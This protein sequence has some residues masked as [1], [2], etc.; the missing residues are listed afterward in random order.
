M[1]LSKFV[2]LF[3]RV[4]NTIRRFHGTSASNIKNIVKDG[5][6]MNKPG[7]SKNKWLYALP[8]YPGVYT[9]VNP[10][11]PYFSPVADD[12]ALVILDIPKDAYRQLPRQTYNAELPVPPPKLMAWDRITLDPAWA[13]REQRFLNEAPNE[14]DNLRE[15]I[16]ELSEEGLSVP[17][18]LIDDYRSGKYLTD[19]LDILDAYRTIVP[20]QQG[21]RVDIFKSDLSPKYISDI[22]YK[23]G[24]G[25]DWF[26]LSGKP[27]PDDMSS[28]DIFK[29]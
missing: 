18:R 5:L 22:L 12:Q 7:V 8:E 11:R 14:Y 26:T 24:T 16:N 2:K 20:I 13:R 15:Q 27:V 23:P 28:T 21:G 1:P 10:T 25:D 4:P 6:S 17:K 3:P 29:Y 9:T 19:E